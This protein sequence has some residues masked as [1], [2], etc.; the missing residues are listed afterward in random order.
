MTAAR[1][2]VYRAQPVP[3]PIVV[4]RPVSH[5][6]WRD[7]WVNSHYVLGG[8][9]QI[10]PW[11]SPNVTIAAGANHTLRFRVRG[12]YAAV[13]RRWSVMA[14]A[15]GKSGTPEIILTMPAGG[16]SATARVFGAFRET[17]GVAHV[18]ELL[19]GVS[20]AEV[21]A[22]I[23]IAVSDSDAAILG[24][25]CVEYPRLS[26]A[27]SAVGE[28]GDDGVDPD[29]VRPGED[30][31]T[32]AYKSI[33]GVV[34]AQANSLKSLRR[35]LIQWARAESTAE[36]KAYASGWADHFLLPIPAL[37]ELP[38]SGDTAVTVHARVL[39]ATTAG[40]GGEFRFNTVSGGTAVATITGIAGTTFAWY[41]STAGAPA[42]FTIH[43]EDLATADGRRGA[44][45]ETI[46]GQGQRTSG[47]L[48]VAAVSVWRPPP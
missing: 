37:G 23:N 10:V 26:L 36:A 20:S 48:Y 30:L 44:A 43:A 35:H 34:E 46:Q 6:A 32:A 38:Y 2:P 18:D 33:E 13:M 8:G 5:A 4:G 45:W 15:P 39:A 27:L 47:T 17:Q 28:T 24:V 7:T 3:G 41:P 40:G 19:T 29:T 21:E 22:S 12:S 25:G 9:R 31:Q 11:F 16:V 1:V 42:S 14:I